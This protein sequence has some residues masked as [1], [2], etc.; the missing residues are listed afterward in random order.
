MVTV[1]FTVV[2]AIFVVMLFS[3]VIVR[4]WPKIEIHK[5]YHCDKQGGGLGWKSC[6]RG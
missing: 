4:G 2:G 1:G 5:H 6:G 3:A